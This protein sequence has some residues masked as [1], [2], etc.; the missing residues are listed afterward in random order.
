M[1][2]SPGEK[3]PHTRDKCPCSS[4]IHDT[5]LLPPL[6]HHWASTVKQPELVSLV[7][8][9]DSVLFPLYAPNGLC[10]TLG[11][12]W[13]LLEITLKRDAINLEQ[14][15]LTSDAVV[16]RLMTPVR[17]RPPGLVRTSRT[18][19]YRTRWLGEGQRS[20]W[21]RQNRN[22]LPGMGEWIELQQRF[23]L[24]QKCSLLPCL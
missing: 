11:H 19:Q 3:S 12:K 5:A 6:W 22:Q 17:S 13:K 16:S 18:F 4:W 21:D 24:E 7:I 1:P 8:N 23:Y 20:T 9:T 14:A 2:L 10:Y 15:L